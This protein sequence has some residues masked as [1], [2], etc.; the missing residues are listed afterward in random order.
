MGSAIPGV[1]NLCENCYMRVR[2]PRTQAVR[3]DALFQV[4]GDHI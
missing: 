3:E 1:F 2:H 4:Q